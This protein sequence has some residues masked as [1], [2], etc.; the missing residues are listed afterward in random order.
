MSIIESLILNISDTKNI[1]NTPK[2]DNFLLNLLQTYKEEPEKI[3]D[4][5]K[6]LNITDKEIK[7]IKTYL[8]K[9][10]KNQI[11]ESQKLINFLEKIKNSLKE[12]SLKSTEKKNIKIP[13]E[14]KEIIEP[15][16]ILQKL[17]VSEIPNKEFSK[18]LQTNIK[19]NLKKP[20]ENI[21]DDKINFLNN[22][23]INSTHLEQKI[24]TFTKKII[25]SKISFEK[26]KLTEI[27]IQT[28]K[29]IKSFKDL[30]NFANKKNLNI[31]KI[32]IAH[33]KDKKNEANSNGF[34]F[35]LPKNKINPRQINT[36][37]KN[38]NHI[39]QETIKNNTD[40][41]NILQDLIKK[42]E[43]DNSQQTELMHQKHNIKNHETTT[44][45]NTINI[46]NFDLN[47]LK[48]NI[49]KAKETIK[50]FTSNLKEAIDNYKP[51]ISKL[52]LELHPKE[53][54]KVDITIVHRGDNLQIQIN[55]N[56]TAISFMHSA[57][58]ELRQNLINMGFTDVNMSF[59][60]NQQQGNKEYRQNQKFANNSNEEND[61][62]IIEI[63]YQY[64]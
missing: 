2:K 15:E 46:N 37:S 63:P 24:V 53:L 9:N 16:N 61:E 45:N 55:S 13:L 58:Q 60:Q 40:K 59:N 42:V 3:I 32:I 14:N 31:S 44:H 47:T 18:I 50:N 33:F 11:F 36:I 20:Q 41:N 35:Q 51:P 34:K 6:S 29:E 30:V 22:L 5:F 1:K 43:S 54:G 64:A 7:S 23:Y 17:I 62:L 10:H 48:Q 12:T 25:E 8:E 21:T 39:P 26:I 56:N 57:Q 19:Q 28:F 27:D 52:S 49:H 38:I 4:L